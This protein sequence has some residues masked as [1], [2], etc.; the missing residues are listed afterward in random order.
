MFSSLSL[1]EVEYKFI[2]HRN[3]SNQNETI[4]FDPRWDLA[5][6]KAHKRIYIKALDYL[7]HHNLL[8]L[9][10]SYVNVTIYS[11]IGSYH[12]TLHKSCTSSSLLINE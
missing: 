9:Q 11:S 10:D 5:M 3:N 7:C 8:K 1:A 4:I 2:I 6:S 12:Y